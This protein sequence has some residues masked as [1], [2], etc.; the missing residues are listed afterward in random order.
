MKERKNLDRLFQEKFK[1]FEADPDEQVWKN[2]E[3]ALKGKKKR[4]VIPIWF[5]IAGV[6]AILLIGFFTFNPFSN[7]NTAPGTQPLQNRPA[8][9]TGEGVA[10]GQGISPARTVESQDPP[11][12][13][14]GNGIEHGDNKGLVETNVPPTAPSVKKDNTTLNTGGKSNKAT[15]SGKEG[16]PGRTQIASGTDSQAAPVINR[17]YKKQ[18]SGEQLIKTPSAVAD[19]ESGQKQNSKLPAKGNAENAVATTNERTYEKYKSNKSKSK[20]VISNP[21]TFSGIAVATGKAKHKKVS[22]ANALQN[23]AVSGVA[24]AS[25]K[26]Q[27]KKNAS[28]EGDLENTTTAV[29]HQDQQNKTQDNPGMTSP[30]TSG[31][32]EIM[33]D[34]PV[35]ANDVAQTDIKKDSLKKPNELEELLKKSQE[36]EEKTAVAKADKWQV[37]TNIAP[38]YFNSA[39]GGSP[40]DQQFAGNSKS[41]E[42]NMSYGVGVNYA[43]SKR[44]SIRA[45]V[46]KFS[47][48]YN[49]KDVLFYAGLESQNLGNITPSGTGSFIQVVNQETAGSNLLPFELAIKDNNNVGYINQQMGY[50][51][52]PMEMSYK[53]LDS[54]FSVS[55]IGGLSTLFLDENAVSIHSG[56]LTA[57]M[58]EANN[59]NDVH[60][61]SN[62]GLGLRYR[63]MKSLELHC[64]PTFKYQIN[65]FSSGAGNFKPYLIGIYSGLSFSF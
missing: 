51:E 49:T 61:S 53:I 60:F 9:T 14:M 5:R 46:N 58:G 59:L 31:N 47:V 29:T 57:K 63:F 35:K 2:I 12:T 65:T 30:K 36:K 10:N 15:S 34:L 38:V 23:T 3:A 48:G 25:G 54:K 6:A 18:H 13:K 33:K 43:V 50:I 19:A 56:A 27:Q 1:D 45:G 22:K 41:Y 7:G 40:I 42:T 32:N 28:N 24:A 64:E 16:A 62:F 17:K 4:R 52:V 37:T 26:T 44:I 55:V 8:S 39:S 20:N 21:S 11:S